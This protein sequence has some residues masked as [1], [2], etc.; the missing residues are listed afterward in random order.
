M[1]EKPLLN[2]HLRR[3]TS[4][5]VHDLVTDATKVAGKDYLV[6][7]VR[8]EFHTSARIKGADN[9]PAAHAHEL[10]PEK[11][12]QYEG[13]PKLYFHCNQ[14]N[15]RGPRIAGFYEQALKEHL[16]AAGKDESEQ[17]VVVLAG[18]IADY[19]KKYQDD[20]TVENLDAEKKE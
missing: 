7:D 10:I 15:G 5:E 18:G 12:K 9:L 13:V 17:E 2:P 8:E 19:K 14:S 3:A 20:G 4:E 16:R 1:S 11:L 6:V